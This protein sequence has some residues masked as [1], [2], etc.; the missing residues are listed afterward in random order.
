MISPSPDS[1]TVKARPN[2]SSGRFPGVVISAR[3]SGGA[4][5]STPALRNE[6]LPAPEGPINASRCGR[7]SFFHIS[8]TS[9][10][11]PKKYSASSSVNEAS[12]G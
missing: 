10:S 4:A 5:S 7:R 11:R 8:S 9:S 12:P 2:A 1:C 6:L 3:Q